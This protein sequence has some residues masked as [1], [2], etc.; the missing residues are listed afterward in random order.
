LFDDGWYVGRVVDISYSNKGEKLFSCRYKDN[1]REV[2]N[3]ERTNTH[4]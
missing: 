2:V 4:D 3:I 1:D